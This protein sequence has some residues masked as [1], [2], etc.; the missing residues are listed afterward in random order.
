VYLSLALSAVSADSEKMTIDSKERVMRDPKGRHT[1]F[2]GVNVV[3]KIPPYIPDA[4][5]YDAQ[6]SLNDKDID[7]LVSWG[8]NFVRLGVMWEAVE[9]SPGNYNST[10]IEE[11]DTMINK[12][13]AKG[14]YTLV[15]AHQDVLARQICG[16]GMPNFYAREVL[17]H[18]S[19]CFGPYADYVLAPIAQ[20]FGACKS[21][22]SYG[23]RK[24]ADGNP[25]IEDCQKNS[26]FIYYTSP[27][28]WTLFRAIYNNDFGM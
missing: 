9:T 7:D 20:L 10:Y 11:V 19:F 1:I 23:M 17:K 27:E 25:L 6:N 22:E 24:D 5:V 14:I 21:L 4:Q 26:F 2:H 13:G 3:Y 18:G 15:D 16:E 28:A 8:F 12:L